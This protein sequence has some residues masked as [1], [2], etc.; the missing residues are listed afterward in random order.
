MSQPR[1]ANKTT[2]RPDEAAPQECGTPG[3]AIGAALAAVGV[4]L[5]IGL[6]T[7]AITA[8][9]SAVSAPNPTADQLATAAKRGLVVGSTVHGVVAT[10][11]GLATAKDHPHFAGANA[12][13]GVTALGAAILLAL[14]PNSALVPS[15]P[16][17]TP[18][19][20]PTLAPGGAIDPVAMLTAY[21]AP[22][23]PLRLS[24]APRMASRPM[25]LISPRRS[26]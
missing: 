2:A 7:G 22:I 6:A 21:G 13:V 16:G 25:A 3:G 14:L 9:V 15:G 4:N 17:A 18:T 24:G 12:Y 23:D 1:P 20:S 10:G 11:I 8:A 26:V 19:P 5:A